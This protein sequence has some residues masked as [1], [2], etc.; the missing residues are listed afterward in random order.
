MDITLSA[1]RRSDVQVYPIYKDE[2]FMYPIRDADQKPG[3]AIWFRSRSDEECNILAVSLGKRSEMKLDTVRR[4]GGLSARQIQKEGLAKAYLARKAEQGYC[5]SDSVTPSEWLHSWLEGWLLGLYSFHKYRTSSLKS[6]KIELVIHPEEWPELTETVL[7]DIINTAKIRAAGTMFAK[8]LVNETPDYLH[9]GRMVEWVKER[10]KDTPVKTKVYKNEELVERQMNGLLRVGAGSVYPPAL[11]ELRYEGDNSLPL[12]SLVGKGITF[13]MGGMNIKSGKNLSD[14]RM[15]LGGAAAVV[16]AMDIL[17]SLRAKVNVVALVAVAENV[18]DAYAMLPSSVV[19]FPNGLTVQVANT[20]AE[21]RLVLADALLHAAGLGAEEAIDMATLTG[22]I[23]Q[24]LGLGIAG[25]WGDAAMTESLVSI[26]ERNG[27]R[28]WPMPL[29]EE[30]ESELHSDYA[31]LCN[32]GSSSLAGAITAALFIRRF[33]TK[34]MKW[35]HID[36]AGTVQYK[37]DVGYS[38][39]GAT[40]YGARLLADYVLSRH[41]SNIT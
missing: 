11:I 2:H 38:A 26:G 41:G 40:G 37:R 36:M 25:I 18:P 6:V 5:S 39:A 4:A 21:G 1:D 8:D 29:M 35:A 9:P 33:V 27:E 17:V 32:I 3:H 15:D 7:L 10:F 24:A 20:D 16:G 22:N 12:I 19:S 31:D 23:G 14:A 30:Y 28:L 13:D 34:S